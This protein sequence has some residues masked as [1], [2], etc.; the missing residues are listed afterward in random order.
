LKKITVNK[1]LSGIITKNNTINFYYPNGLIKENYRFKIK[2]NNIE[3]N[4]FRDL[5]S[6]QCYEYYPDNKIKSYKRYYFKF[7]EDSLQI[8]TTSHHLTALY[9][10][11]PNGKLKNYVEIYENYS[12]YN[13][14]IIKQT[15]N[16]DGNLLTDSVSY[17]NGYSN[18]TSS[19][20]DSKGRIIMSI[21]DSWIPPFI[22]EWKYNDQ[23][24]VIYFLERGKNNE[25]KYERFDHYDKANRRTGYRVHGYTH[26]T[27]ISDSS[28]FIYDSSMIIE[29]K[30]FRFTHAKY[31]LSTIPYKE[32]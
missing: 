14:M 6:K 11:H 29:K 30:Y 9:E 2:K 25:S 24:S 31:T 28:Y 26:C 21:L 10:Y 23:D 5:C 1:S 22:R 20:Y 4:D 13:K 32:I 7:L 3:N 15:Y 19:F 12:K 18:N 17:G 8:L 16:L 27:S